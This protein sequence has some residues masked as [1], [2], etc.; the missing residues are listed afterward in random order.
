MR[1]LVKHREEVSEGGSRTHRA[2]PTQQ[3]LLAAVGSGACNDEMSNSS[4]SGAIA[5]Q[6]LRAMGDDAG[7]SIH[8]SLMK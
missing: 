2:I 5:S 3:D 6:K 1:S 8:K 7:K 4:F